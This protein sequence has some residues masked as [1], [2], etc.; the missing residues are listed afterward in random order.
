[1]AE[2][3]S[4]LLTVRAKYKPSMKEAGLEGVLML[5]SAATKTLIA[6]AEVLM[7]MLVTGHRF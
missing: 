1:M 5:V 2:A 7:Q 4:V 3:E 6:V